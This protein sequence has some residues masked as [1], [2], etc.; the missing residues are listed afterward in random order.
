MVP[1]PQRGMLLGNN[2]IM[3]VG[4]AV[5]ALSHAATGWFKCSCAVLPCVW[6]PANVERGHS[7]R[8]KSQAPGVRCR[9]GKGGPGLAPASGEVNSARQQI[10][11]GHFQLA[12]A[13]VWGVAVRVWQPE[14]R[15]SETLWHV[16]QK[17]GEGKRSEEGMWSISRGNKRIQSFRPRPKMAI[18]GITR[19]FGES[20]PPLW[21]DY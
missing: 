20:I 3:S 7:R 18:M 11:N 15:A 9:D 19:E 12:V 5:D 16:P 14:G 1:S 13:V 4:L 21:N 8:Q 6:A 17:T 2:V 10:V